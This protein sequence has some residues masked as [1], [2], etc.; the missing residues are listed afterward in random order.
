MEKGREESQTQNATEVG[1]TWRD[2]K[3]RWKGSNGTCARW[4]APNWERGQR[5]AEHSKN[6]GKHWKWGHTEEEGLRQGQLHVTQNSQ[7]S[8]RVKTTGGGKPPKLKCKKEQT[9][10]RKK[11]ISKAVEEYWRVRQRS[12][13][14]QRKRKWRRNKNTKEG[15][16]KSYDLG[17]LCPHHWRKKERKSLRATREKK[18]HDI[19]RNE[20]KNSHRLLVRSENAQTRRQSSDIFEVWKEKVC[21]PRILYPAKRSS[22]G[23]RRNR[24]FLKKG[25][26]HFQQTSSTKNIKKKFFM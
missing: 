24:D 9:C 23:W 2:L 20:D 8:A 7:E 4:A 22:K 17:V 6:Q 14:S 21:K 25:G 5:E 10:I 1:T 16:K 12:K 18:T 13:W 3:Q 26:I 11:G 19:L 15:G